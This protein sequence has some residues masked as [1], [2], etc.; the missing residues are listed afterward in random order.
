M[1]IR[2]YEAVFT[3]WWWYNDSINLRGRQMKYLFQA[4]VI[5]L[6]TLVGE[7]LNIIIPL[8]VPASIYGLIIMLICLKLRVIKLE[9]VEG[10]GGFL[11]EIMPVLF[12]PASVGLIVAWRKLQEMM[13]PF[14]VITVVTTFLV[15]GATGWV[16]QLTMKKG[17]R[18]RS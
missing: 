17:K 15:M 18:G 9:Q 16:A 6:V 3:E 5:M 11:L 4:A 1:C 7:L 14:L 2:K 10:T 13:L 8:P 12:V